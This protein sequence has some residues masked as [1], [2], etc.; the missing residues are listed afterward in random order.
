MVR[1]P[2]GA[3][4]GRDPIRRHFMWKGEGGL[5]DQATRMVVINS[6]DMIFAPRIARIRLRRLVTSHNWRRKH[7]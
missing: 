4:R 7:E 1:I 5:T 6:D 2:E 3:I